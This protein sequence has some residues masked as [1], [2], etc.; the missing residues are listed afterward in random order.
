MPTQKG[1]YFLKDGTRV[2]SVTTVLSHCSLGGCDG[3]IHWA[4]K[5][6]KE[7]KD[8]QTVRDKAADA[9][10]MAHDA[11]E[12]WAKGQ[13]PVFDGPEDIVKRAKLAFDG[14]LL[15]ADQS[16]FT[17]T[18]T[19]IP[20]V[21]EKHRFGGTFDAVM[22]NGKRY[23]GDHKTSGSVRSRFLY[24]VRAYGGLWEEN[25]RDE[26]INGYLLL[27]FDGEYGDFHQHQ[28]V[29]LDNA[30]RG[31]LMMRELYEIEKEMRKRVS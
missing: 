17:I 3:L 22:M 29:D 25:V 2:P 23:M 30:W 19:E 11:F 26:P 7:G 6:A 9:G 31:F 28:W 4:V 20:F 1:G 15:W 27:R 18:H 5:L 21:S 24:Q 12:A 8:W 13:E 16:K 10:T 14:F